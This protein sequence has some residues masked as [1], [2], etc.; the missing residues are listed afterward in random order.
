[1]RN[2]LRIKILV[3]PFFDIGEERHCG[4]DHLFGYPFGAETVQEL[5]DANAVGDI[6]GNF[7]SLDGRLCDTEL[8]SRIISIDISELPSH[9]MVIGMGGGQKKVRSILGALNGHYL[10]VL[11]TDVQTSEAVLAEAS[12][13]QRL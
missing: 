12:V 5:V 13:S 3:A 1:M 4:A 6:C 2:R 8:R 10:H 11:I 9:R 7:F